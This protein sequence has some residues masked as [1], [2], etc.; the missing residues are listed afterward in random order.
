MKKIN[1]IKTALLSLTAMAL[2]SSCLKDKRYIDFAASKPLI[3]FPAAAY[4]G[5]FQVAG[6]A[7]S[8]T[9]TAFPIILNIASPSV[10]ST[11]T[12]VTVSVNTAA[13]DAYNTANGTS[14]VPLPAADYTIN[15][16]TVTIPANT[17]QAN[18][19]VNINTVA[20]GTNANY[21]LP[22]T[23]TA[24]SGGLIID[25]YNTML[26]NVTVKNLYDDTYT[27]TG[28]KFHPTVGASHALTGN[29][30]YSSR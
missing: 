14:Y 19:V 5:E 8:S 26:Y 13:L 16:N 9:P 25:Q 27:E 1:Y 15:S 7:A 12:T 21:V 22:V 29:F 10:L 30:K 23:I 17:R 3:E 18:Y 11:A 20:V 2:L 6:V 28:Y 4:G 24:V